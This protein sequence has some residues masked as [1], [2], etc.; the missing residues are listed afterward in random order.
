L[1]ASKR[2]NKIGYEEVFI[3]KRMSGKLAI[4]L[5]VA[6]CLMLFAGCASKDKDAGKQNE[7]SQTTSSQVAEGTKADPNALPVFPLATPIT[8]KAMMPEIGGTYKDVPAMQEFSKKT[9]ITIQFDIAPIDDYK[10]KQSVILASGNLPDAM[11]LAATNGKTIRDLSVEFGSQGLLV[12]FKDYLDKMPNLKMWIEKFPKMKN[13]VM[14]E[15]E[16]FYTIVDGQTTNAVYESYLINEKA[17]QKNNIAVPTTIDEYYN[18]LKKLKE[19]YPKSTPLTVRWGFGHI[20]GPTAKLFFGNDGTYYN[21]AQD[22][23]MYGPLED[24]FKKALEF[25]NKLYKEKL[26]DPEFA[27]LSDEQWK[28]KLINEKAFVT[29]DYKH[30]TRSLSGTLQDAGQ[31]QNPDNFKMIP[32]APFKNGEKD[33]KYW[34]AEAVNLSWGISINTKSQYVKE[35]VKLMDWQLTDEYITLANWGIEGTTYNIVNGK[36]VFMDTLK[37][38]KNPNGTIELGDIVSRY[39]G[40]FPKGDN[41]NDQIGD[42]FDLYYSDKVLA[43]GDFDVPWVLSVSKEKSEESANIMTPIN[44]YVDECK[45]KFITGEMS[46]DKWDEFVKKVI[47][48]GIDKA[49]AINNEALAKVKR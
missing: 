49:L 7:I 29:F 3:M 33:T 4:V 21:S 46:F 47:D 10:E 5:S 31:K 6:M 45:I 11:C 37:N 14:D 39:V 25:L 41:S 19:I 12:N 40:L 30:E 42:A 20:L 44:T 27:T 26:L 23:Y 8:I 32:V 1:P 38:S 48:M 18:A 28:E 13:G 36:K 35:L 34:G 24:N 22:K 17:F 15:N 16:N 43:Y 9:G 2:Y